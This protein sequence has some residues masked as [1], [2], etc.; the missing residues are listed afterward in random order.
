MP[1]PNIPP[2]VAGELHPTTET[3]AAAAASR[4]LAEVDAVR[5]DE[6][7]PINRS[8][9]E[10]VATV[11]GANRKIQEHL[12]ALAS[13]P[14]I[15]IDRIR[16]LGDYA[17]AL[18]YWNSGTTYASTPRPEVAAL[19]E[20]GIVE[21]ERILHDLGS[22]SRRGLFDASLLA[23]FGETTAYVKVGNDLIGLAKLVKEHWAAL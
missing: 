5:D 13:L 11:L 17:Q 20:R 12:P 21:R 1:N 7:E 15:E 8:L 19:V 18:A 14:G 2:P 16:K 10:I 23:N 9:A 22:F 4:V 3:E 6:L